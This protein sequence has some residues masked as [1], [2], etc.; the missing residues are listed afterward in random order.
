MQLAH[1]LT[2][3]I[4]PLLGCFFAIHYEL[5]YFTNVVLIY[6]LP[7][8]YLT[9][10]NT[11]RRHA[12][13]RLVFALLVP[14]AFAFVVD[15]IGTVSSLWTVPHT[16]LPWRVY[17]VIPLEDFVWM[18]GG[19][20]TI[21]TCYEFFAGK[22]PGKLNTR[23][24]T[25]FSAIAAFGLAI[26]FALSATHPELFVWHNRFAYL[27]LGL[28]FAGIPTIILMAR[29]WRA[30]VKV[31]YVIAYFLFL[32][33]TLEYTETVL[34]QWLFNGNYALRPL[35]FAGSPGIPYEELF[36][37]GI[38]EVLIAVGFYTFF[39]SQREVVGS[40]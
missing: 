9:C 22:T 12:L 28:T 19:V 16:F 6:I 10:V 15:Y 30:Y 36:F 11:N 1:I 21:M 38:V 4:L 13:Q 2:L 7:G 32:T 39:T 26:F 35:A 17:A 24:L 18:I 29:F 33:V 23:K 20:Y 5:S 14:F 27:I 25:Y 40:K 31:Y 3:L 34:G 8:L 37:V